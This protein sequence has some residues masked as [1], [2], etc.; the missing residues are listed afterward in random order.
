MPILDGVKYPRPSTYTQSQSILT[1]LQN[2]DNS[3]DEIHTNTYNINTNIANLDDYNELDQYA[4]PN[5]STVT[6]DWGDGSEHLIFAEVHNA[7]FKLEGIFISLDA[8]AW[9]NANTWTFHVYVAYG[10][11][12][13]WREA[14]TPITG[15]AGGTLPRVI[16]V[17]DLANISGIQIMAESDNVGDN[18]T[19]IDYMYLRKDLE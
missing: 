17:D 9:A 10:E 19:S 18:N 14:G 12:A 11:D 3:V 2:I 16:P 4:D 5:I 1:N 7:R 13:D 6:A 15:V 8:T